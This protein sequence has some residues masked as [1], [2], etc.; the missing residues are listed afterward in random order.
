MDTQML[1][2]MARIND[3]ENVQGELSRMVECDMK[4]WALK[5]VENVQGELLNI[6]YAKARG[7]TQDGF[8][9]MEVYG[10]E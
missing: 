7:W 10:D 6:C 9:G 1:S 4:A 8:T 3:V 5:D 2:E